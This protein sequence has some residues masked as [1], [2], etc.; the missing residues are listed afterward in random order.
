[1]TQD[2][3]DTL[4]RKG[5]LKA[6]IIAIMLSIVLLVTMILPAEYNIDPLGIGKRLGLTE[7]ADIGEPSTVSNANKQKANNQEGDQTG[8]Q[9]NEIRLEVD[10]GSGL[11]YKFYLEQ[12]QSLTYQWTVNQGEIYFDFHGEPANDD[13]GYFESYTIASA[14]QSEGTIT[15]PFAGTHG[16]YFKNNGERKIVITLKTQG[17]YQ[18]RGLVN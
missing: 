17:V 18:L 8:F 6:I 12:Y 9:S 5:L 4:S 16:W 7:L 11:E 1:M 10:P 13:S 2:T 14:S 15:V 3:T